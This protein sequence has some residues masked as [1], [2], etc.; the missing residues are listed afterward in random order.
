MHFSGGPIRYLT[1]AAD[2]VYFASYNYFTS[3]YFPRLPHVGTC[4][5]E[6]FAAFTGCAI[7]RSYLLL[8]ISFYF[9]TYKKA[10]KNV[11][12]SAKK[13]ARDMEKKEVPGVEETSEKATEALKAAN[14]AVVATVSELQKVPGISETSEKASDSRLRT[15]LSRLLFVS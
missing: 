14:S 5:G 4:A 12:R 15:G 13:A 8:F 7:L 2:F 11:K 6:E 10:G 3:T 1:S 9:S